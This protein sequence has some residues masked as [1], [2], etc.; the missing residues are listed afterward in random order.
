MMHFMDNLTV[1]SH[2]DPMPTRPSLRWAQWPAMR[3]APEKKAL[4]QDA[5][6][7]PSREIAQITP[8]P[9]SSMLL[10]LCRKLARQRSN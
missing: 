10:G 3:G 8:S 5:G 4:P 6:A 7:L 9:R 2:S 1:P